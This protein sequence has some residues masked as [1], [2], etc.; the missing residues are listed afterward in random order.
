[1]TTPLWCLA[2]ILLMPYLIATYG[3]MYRKR[4]FGIMDNENPRE[5][6]GQLDAT[7]KRIY[8]AQ[9]N[10]WEN[11]TA[12]TGSVAIALLAGA[13]PEQAGIPSLVYVLMRII[14]PIAY[15]TGFSTLRSISNTTGLVCCAALVTLGALSAG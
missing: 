2:F 3:A 7:G 12:F 14:H 6:A 13:S 8:A 1:M 11:A 15:I 4:Q 5:Q 10:A 9:Q